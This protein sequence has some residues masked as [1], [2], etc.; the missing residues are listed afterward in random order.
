MTG[1]KKKILIALLSAT[2]ITAGAIGLSACGGNKNANDSALYAIYLAETNNG[3]TQTYQ[4]W[5]ESKLSAP[6]D[7]QT[8]YIGSNGNW[9]IGNTDTGVKAAGTDGSDGTD[10]SNGRGIDSIKIIG[11]EFVVFYTDGTYELV[12]EA[13]DVPFKLLKATAVDQTGAHIPNVYFQLYYYDTE[14]YVNE[15][16]GTAVTDSDGTAKFIYVPQ[17]GISYRISLADHGKTEY[18]PSFP[19]GYR[20]DYPIDPKHNWTINYFT[21]S[22][23]NDTLQTM[24]IPFEDVSHSFT[25]ASVHNKIV[26]IPYKRKYSETAADK[27]EEINGTESNA[28]TVNVKAGYHTYLSFLSYVSPATSSDPEETQKLLNNAT[29]AATGKY[30]FTIN[31]GFSPVLYFYEGN[32]GN[33]PADELGIPNII[34]SHTG[35]ATDGSDQ[36]ATGTNSLTINNDTTAVRGEIFFGLYSESDCTV[37][38]TVERTGDAE[39]IPAP[40]LIEVP[41]PAN[42]TQWPNKAA[43]ETLTLM[44]VTGAFSAVKGTDGYYHVNSANGPKLVVMLTKPVSRYL[45]DFSLQA[46][47]ESNDRGKSVM[48]FNPSDINE[49]F[50]KD[51]RYPLKKYDYNA[52]LTEYCKWVNKDGVY[53]VDDTLYDLLTNLATT[54]T[55]IDFPHA[56]D[57]CQWLL[58]CYYYAPAGG[59]TAPGSGTETDPYRISTGDNNVNMTGLGGT[60]TLKLSVSE[61]GVYSLSSSGSGKITVPQGYTTATINGVLH[62]LMPEAGDLVVTLTGS[63][64]TYKVEVEAGKNIEAFL[65]SGSEDDE[66]ATPSQGIDAGSAIS[67]IGTGVWNILDNKEVND[68]VYIKFSCDFMGGGTYT[69]TLYGG[70]A[71]LTYGSATATTIT[72]NAEFDNTEMKAKEY[73]V[74]VKA[75][76]TANLML[77][78][79]KQ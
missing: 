17:E 39:E 5:L 69:L 24:D 79:T 26:A 56:A 73:V 68:G 78:I 58:P 19:E 1:L 16:V 44:P 57:G 77:V 35:N 30:K 31:G 13:D 46:Y 65:G 12:E 22:Q 54:G 34:I 2:C 71:T 18:D 41:A 36:V 60:A 3:A 37:T 9:W 23:S 40:Q 76:E 14:N 66:D 33:M 15:T 64:S 48:H 38:L 67:V 25:N 70:D 59:I 52:V 4:Q 62:V 20:I 75:S 29:K 27:A 11:G 43:D 49:Y 53:G 42:L 45:P 74:Y 10:G 8:P 6:S 21:V 55:G 32:T 51:K 63:A 28:F 47:P 61:A 50:N 72:I 7:G